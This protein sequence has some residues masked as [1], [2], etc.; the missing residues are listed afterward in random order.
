[1]T[2]LH[3]TS[4]QTLRRCRPAQ[5]LFVAVALLAALVPGSRALADKN[6]ELLQK[7]D[8]IAKEVAALRG[9]AQLEPI[10]RGV[11]NKEQIRKRLIARIDEE[12]TP[13]E[14][15]AEQLALQRFGLLP[16]DADY[17]HLVVELLTDQI[18]GFYDPAERRL[19]IANWQQNA[20]SA[21]DDMLM[22][23][24]IDHALQ[25]QHFDLRTFMKS[26]KDDADA[27]VARQALVEG[28]GTAL[29]VEYML[30]DS[31]QSPWSNSR[32]L[33][34]IRTQ[35]RQGMGDTLDKAPLALR[36]GLLFPYLGGLAFV[37]HFRKKHPWS[38]IDDIFRKP[39]LSTEQVLHPDKYEAYEQPY[40]IEA[41]TLAALRDHVEVYSNV[42]G[43][44]GLGLFLRQHAPSAD[45]SNEALIDKANQAAAGWGGDRAVVYAPPDHAGTL[46]G[47]IGVL[48]SVWDRPVDAIEFFE[49]LDDGMASLSGGTMMEG[50]AGKD[51]KAEK[52]DKTGKKAKAGRTG[53]DSVEYLGADGRVFKAERRDSTV[54]LVVSAPPDKARA[55]IDQ[56]FKSWRVR[57]R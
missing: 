43:E 48:Y 7:A 56:A 10:A 17:K 5:R 6:T 23:H 12:Y 42:T 54:V 3:R 47:T 16:P 36:E 19:Y 34:I 38:R 26:G 31:K 14:L 4:I 21:F 18:A 40:L 32:I 28:D 1:M 50:N 8:S 35:T 37:V 9:L 52:K 51:G 20:L 53:I 13:K 45:K 11:M 44:Y 2:R 30:R 29:M 33:D 27:S 46:A 57:R 15:A 41:R 55:I 25:D 49:M 24:E 39:P 22:A